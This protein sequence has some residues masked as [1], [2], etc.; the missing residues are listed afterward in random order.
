MSHCLLTLYIV[1]KD[2]CRKLISMLIAVEQSAIF[3]RNEFRNVIRQLVQA[4]DC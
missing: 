2:W 1:R 4:L 3:R